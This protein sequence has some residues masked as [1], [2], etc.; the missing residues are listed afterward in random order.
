MSSVQFI[1]GNTYRRVPLSDAKMDRSGTYPKTHDWTLYLDVL[2]GSDPDLIERVTFDLGSSFSPPTFVCASPVSVTRPN[3]SPAWRFQTRQQTYGPVTATVQIRGT[4]GTVLRTEHRVVLDAQACRKKPAVF[5]FHERN[6]PKPLKPLKVPDQQCF[7]V[8]LELTSPLGVTLETIAARVPLPVEVIRNYREGR[9]TST[10]WKMVPDSSIVCSASLPDC[11]KF[12]LV[13]PVLQGGSGLGQVSTVLRGL[14]DIEPKLKVN[15]SMGFHIHVDVSA[16]ALPQLIKVCQNFIK[17]EDVLDGLMPPSRRSG[18][19]ESDEFFQSNRQTVSKALGWDA[20]NKQ[21]HEALAAC[22][23]TLELVKM[24]NWDGRYYK[25]N[26]QN[27]SSG[28]Q[29]TIEFRQHSATMSYEKVSAWA[30]FCIAFVTNSAKLAPPSPLAAGRSLEYQ[31]NA[32][33]GY[34]IKDRALRNF[35][36]NRLQKMADG[37]DDDHEACCSGCASGG[38]CSAGRKRQLYQVGYLDVSKRSSS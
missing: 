20:N 32:L 7:G 24:M 13:S 1:V 29:P 12:E 18:S 22:S 2:E 37:D 33:F 35:Y 3:G 9:S 36:Q 14:G 31:F 30:R 17:Y 28:R 4:G 38:A 23:N 25:L 11:N 10:N 15:K 16:L 26:L 6:R 5:T 21:R 8:E 34:V 19:A 27:L